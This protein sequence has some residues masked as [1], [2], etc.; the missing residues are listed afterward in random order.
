MHCAQP[1]QLW[2]A[3]RLYRLQPSRLLCPWNSPGKKAGASYRL[4]FRGSS[5]PRDRTRISCVPCIGRQVLQ[6]WATWEVLSLYR[7][8]VFLKAVFKYY[9]AFEA[10]MYRMFKIT[11]YTVNSYCWNIEKWFLFIHLIP[12]HFIKCLSFTWFFSFKHV[13]SFHI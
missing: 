10:P 13:K 6:H 9:I 11:F 2:P 4:P 5:P 12:S 8:C 7:S 1:T 3:L